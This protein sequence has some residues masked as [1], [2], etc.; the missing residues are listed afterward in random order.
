MVETTDIQV[1]R[2]F[3]VAKEGS[4]VKAFVDL[5]LGDSFVVKG[6]RVVEGGE[7]GLFIGMPQ[8]HGKD[9]KWYDTFIPAT[10]EKRQEIAEV[11]LAAYNG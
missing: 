11:I 9:G 10:P 3:R 4:K 8:E 5:S 7:D 2:L 1:A 6:F